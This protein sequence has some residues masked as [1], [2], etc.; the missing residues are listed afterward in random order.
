[1]LSILVYYIIFATTTG[2]MSYFAIYRPIFKHIEEEYGDVHV[3]L[4]YPITTAAML[5]FFGA[6][7]APFIIKTVL[8]GA[9][10]DLIEEIIKR[11]TQ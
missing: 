6:L 8:V 3:V 1:M 9:D 11:F 4:D 10:E 7:S 2:I 5:M